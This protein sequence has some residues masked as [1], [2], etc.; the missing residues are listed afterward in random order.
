MNALVHMVER[1]TSI[2]K[3]CRL[4]AIHGKHIIISYIV[5]FYM[6][7]LKNIIV[8]YFSE[9]DNGNWRCSQEKCDGVCIAQG[10]PH[11]TT[12]DGHRFSYQ[13]NCKYVL[14]QTTDQKF[15]VVSENIPCGTSGVTCTKNIFIQYQG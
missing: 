2:W 13:G 11:F 1:S 10:D 9:C 8:L 14:A 15:R 3:P 4:D 7:N 6:K 12:F 5:L